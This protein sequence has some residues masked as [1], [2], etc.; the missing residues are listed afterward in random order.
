MGPT[1]FGSMGQRQHVYHFNFGHLSILETTKSHFVFDKL[2]ALIRISC[3]SRRKIFTLKANHLPIWKIKAWNITFAKITIIKK[4]CGV[5]SG[6]LKS[7][8]SL[9]ITLRWFC[10]ALTTNIQ[11]KTLFKKLT[12]TSQPIPF[13]ICYPIKDFKS[14]NFSLGWGFF[15]HL[16]SLFFFGLCTSADT[17]SSIFFR[18]NQKLSN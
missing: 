15:A 13:R 17:F 3:V 12:Q 16:V 2:N 5:W 8:K 7:L 6:M 10:W 1:H 14:F 9:K 4:E 11:S 18:F